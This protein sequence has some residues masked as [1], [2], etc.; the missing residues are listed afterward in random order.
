MILYLKK[1]LH[2]KVKIINKTFHFIWID[3][4]YIILFI[5]VTKKNI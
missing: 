5:V 4:E 2:K 3:I 1:K